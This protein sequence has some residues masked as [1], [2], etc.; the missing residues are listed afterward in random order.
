MLTQSDTE[1]AC[2]FTYSCYIFIIQNTLKRFSCRIKKRKRFFQILQREKK[3]K[4]RS[5]HNKTKKKNKK[6]KTKP[7][8]AKKKNNYETNNIGTTELINN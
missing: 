4:Q 3:K 2:D 6:E 5:L 1:I 8:K 7:N